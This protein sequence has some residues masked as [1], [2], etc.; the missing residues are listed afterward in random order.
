MKPA[1]NSFAVLLIPFIGSAMDNLNDPAF[2]PGLERTRDLLIGI[3]DSFEAKREELESDLDLTIQARQ[4]RVQ[5]VR[6]AALEQVE[7]VKDLSDQEQR[8]R[9]KIFAPGPE[10]SEIL[11]LL[12]FLKGQEIRQS[13][14]HLDSLQLTARLEKALSGGEDF[15]IDAVAA[16]PVPLVDSEILTGI[17]ERRAFSRLE[18]ENPALLQEFE[19]VKLINGLILGMKNVTR[20]H[21][22]Q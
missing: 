12:D 16:S 19:D 13:L 21:F 5:D 18:A 4:R 1:T 7:N 11:Q 8:L 20:Q 14:G 3:A 6:E 2:L 15:I 10:K 22:R 9:A 17:L